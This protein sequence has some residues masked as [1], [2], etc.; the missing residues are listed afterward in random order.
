MNKV[1]FK[2]ADMA[3]SPVKCVANIGETDKL[4]EQDAAQAEK[5]LVRVWVGMRSNTTSETFYQLRA[6][7]AVEL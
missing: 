2:Q 3:C 7:R 1:G 6:V 5:Y 4:L